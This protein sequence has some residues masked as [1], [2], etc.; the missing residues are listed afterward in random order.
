[1]GEIVI[2]MKLYCPAISIVLSYPVLPKSNLYSIVLMGFSD[3]SECGVNSLEFS[4]G[5]LSI[6]LE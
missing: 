6:A 4:R 5:V 2:M 1:M 3:S